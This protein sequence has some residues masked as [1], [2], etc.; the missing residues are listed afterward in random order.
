MSAVVGRT[1]LRHDL[2]RLRICAQNTQRFDEVSAVYAEFETF[3][4]GRRWKAPDLPAL[5]GL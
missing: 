3:F 1:D 5:L 4:V 2:L